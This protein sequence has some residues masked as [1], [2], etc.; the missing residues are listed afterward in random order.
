MTDAKFDD[1]LLTNLEL[2]HALFGNWDY[3]LAQ[4]GSGLWNT[5]VIQL[6]NQQLVPVAGDFDLS[7]WVT[8]QARPDAPHD[9]RP[10]LP[11]IERQAHYET[12]QIL[13][14]A[15]VARFEVGRN[16]FREARAAIEAQIASAE[17][18]EP[19]RTNALRHVAAFYDA[20]AEALR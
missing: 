17:V 3:R 18:D 1:Q 8:E 19:G 16:Y 15:G 20:L 6:A 13:A 11:E 9:Y 12:E 4:I 7:S 2:L 5:D 14:R 10:D